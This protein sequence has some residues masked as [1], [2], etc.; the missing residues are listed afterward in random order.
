MTAVLPKQ[1][2]T[3]AVTVIIE[4]LHRFCATRSCAD[5]SVARHQIADLYADHPAAGDALW[6][7]TMFIHRTLIDLGEGEQ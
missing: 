6:G 4:Q 7:I 5:L 2:L 1:D 3:D